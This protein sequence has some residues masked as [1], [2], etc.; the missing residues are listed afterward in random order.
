[1]KNNKT[2]AVVAVILVI[3]VSLFKNNN[4]TIKCSSDSGISIKDLNEKSVETSV[5]GTISANVTNEQILGQAI[6]ASNIKK[7][8]SNYYFGGTMVGGVC[9]E[10]GVCTPVLS[11]QTGYNFNNYTLEAKIGNFKRTS[12]TTTGVDAQFGNYTCVLGEGAGVNNAM[13]LSLA[14]S[15]GAKFGVGYQNGDNFYTFTGGN[16]YVF[17]EFP[18][19]KYLKL[20]GGA[21]FADSVTGY[22]AVKAI[23]GN[24]SITI[25]S[26]KLGS[27]EQNVVA[28]YSR[29]NIK[30]GSNEFFATTVAWF[31]S[32]E[33][34][35]HTILG[36]NKNNLNLFSQ[37]GF[38][39]TNQVISP[40]FGFG[41]KLNF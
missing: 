32:Q 10:F 33:Q 7:N 27:K 19:G 31:K 35:V 41:T 30:V 34:G 13:Q 18:I 21:D 24:N 3:V 16:P 29:S 1:M 40:V 23:S 28:S 2:L 14:L 6:I 9:S 22:A 37:L 25:T 38:K 39:V 11:I 15:K 5:S 4:T 20:S 26:N 17:T 12:I 36:L 8:F